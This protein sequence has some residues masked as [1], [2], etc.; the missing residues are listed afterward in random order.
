MARCHN[1]L[2]NEDSTI[3]ERADSLILGELET[4]FGI[5][6]IIGNSH[7]FATT[8]S[9]SLDHNWVTN[10]VGNAQNL[11]HIFDLIEEA[12][13]ASYSSTFR[14]LFGFN[15][16]SH[17][18]DSFRSRSNEFNIGSL[19]QLLELRVLRQ[20]AIARMHGLSTRSLYHIK[21]RVHQKI[22]LIGGRR[23]NSEG[24]VGFFDEH[25]V[26]IGIRVDS[27]SLDVHLFTCLDDTSCDLTA[28]GNQDAIISL[29]VASLSTIAILSRLMRH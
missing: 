9:A 21:D 14:Q 19:E 28:I 25:R 7:A 23:S 11:S 17:G 20:E 18:N 27:H 24:L 10:F 4:L 22:T 8:S 12:W 26:T 6:V 29:G 16:V 13:H 2:F 5:L 1:I 3:T 15:F